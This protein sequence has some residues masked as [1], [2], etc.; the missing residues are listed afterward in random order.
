MTLG[1]IIYRSLRQHAL[2]TCVAAASIALACGLAITVWVVKDQAQTSFSN[3]SAGFDAVLGARGSRLQLVLNAVFHLEASPGNISQADY[4]Q[5]TAHPAV[6]HAVPIAV[7]DNYHG[8]R[9]V[10]VPY[11]KL[12]AVELTPGLTLT[13]A[14]GRPFADGHEA[15]VGSFAAQRLGLAVGSTFHPYHGLYFDEAAQHA[16]TYAVVGVLQPTN[17]PLDRVILIPLA[18]VQQMSGH[19]AATATD[20]SAVLIKLRS[21]MAG[22][23]LDLLYNKQG[24]RLTFAWPV[25]SV[26]GELF[27]KIAWFQD[28]LALVAYGVALVAIGSVLVSVY[29]SM[30]ARRR[31][32]AILRALGARRATVFLA[33][34]GESVATGL[35]GALGGLAL[36]LGMMSAAAVIIRRETGVQLDVVAWAPVMALV[37]AALLLLCA[38]AGLVP[39]WKAYRLPV[40]D[41]LAP[42]S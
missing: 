32:I 35:A 24:N 27:G 8:F 22:R 18:G 33:V 39:A 15:V 30:T 4:E 7:G 29:S 28:V 19:A 9:L 17:T 37:P 16:E 14:N 26:V 6:L 38:L 41:A 2:S 13:L 1:R 10:G 21:P 5:I 42:V 34:L 23:S 25:A 11:D 3:V 12:A 31:D 36:H 40:A 20:V